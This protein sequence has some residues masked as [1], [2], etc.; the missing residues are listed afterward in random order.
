WPGFV[1]LLVQDP[2][3]AAKT[4]SIDP[5]HTLATTAGVLQPETNNPPPAYWTID[6]STF[7]FRFASL[8][9]IRNVYDSQNRKQFTSDKPAPFMKPM[10]IPASV[11]VTSDVTISIT[12]AQKTD[13]SDFFTLSPIIKKIPAAIWGPYDSAKDPSNGARPSSLLTSDDATVDQVM[14]FDLGPCTTTESPDIIQLDI[15]NECSEDVFA[16]SPNP[17]FLP[18]ALSIPLTLPDPATGS[19]IPLNSSVDPS[20]TQYASCVSQRTSWVPDFQ[21]D[22]AS[23]AD[24]LNLLFKYGIEDKEIGVQDIVGSWIAFKG[25]DASDQKGSGGRYKKLGE[26]AR[27]LDVVCRPF[28]ENGS[29]PPPRIAVGAIG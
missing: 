1:A 26:S 2:A 20:Q 23:R 10:H 19:Q 8:F 4:P 13:I 27:G 3:S 7:A 15:A 16:T 29:L 17:P 9:P 6:A 22:K 25:L 14:G 21:F 5:L 18:N 24:R 28:Q 12:N 11:D